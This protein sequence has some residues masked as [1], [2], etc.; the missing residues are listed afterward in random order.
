MSDN[1]LEYSRLSYDPIN[2]YHYMLMCSLALNG[3][4]VLLLITAISI[5]GGI[6]STEKGV[7]AKMVSDAQHDLEN[8][9]DAY[10]EVHPYLKQMGSLFNFTHEA[11]RFI[12]G[13]ELCMKAYGLCNM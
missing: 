9:H 5:I 3:I 7:I 2:K 4:T 8:M 6:Y 12:H 11:T 1:E 10:T 13:A